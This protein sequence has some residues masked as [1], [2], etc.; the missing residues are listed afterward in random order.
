MYRDGGFGRQILLLT[1]PGTSADQ[2]S[3]VLR[4]GRGC[5]LVRE[6]TFSKDTRQAFC[7]QRQ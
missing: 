7:S 6:G 5:V 1:P 2:F 4:R 3:G